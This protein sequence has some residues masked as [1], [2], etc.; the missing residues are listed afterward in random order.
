MNHTEELKAKRIRNKLVK[1]MKDYCQK[2]GFTDVVF[3]LSGGLDSAVVLA[4]ACDALGSD[5]VHTI[6]MTTQHTSNESVILAAKAAQLNNVDHRIIN[7]Q[8]IVEAI[9]ASLDFDPTVKTVPEN[10]QARARGVVSMAYSNE[11]KWLALSCGN[12]SELAMGYCTLYGDMCG[13]ISPIGDVYKTEVYAI[14]ELYNKE[15]KIF[16]PNQ[17][18]KRPPTAEL[19]N[20]Q[21]D[22][23]SLPPYPILDRILQQYIFGKQEPKTKEEDLVNWVKMQYNRN[24]FKRKQA[25][26]AIII[27]DKERTGLIVNLSQEINR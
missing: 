3:G 8:P 15:G 18:I 11:K 6:M 20:G 25:A 19:S 27:T 5:K 17:I 24:E 26:P 13:G 14:A 23:D 10:I 2:N 1:E 21:K 4:L 16:V 7:V 12:K 22:E 9:K